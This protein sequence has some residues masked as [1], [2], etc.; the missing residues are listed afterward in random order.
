MS[1]GVMQEIKPTIATKV[2]RGGRNCSPFM[3][4]LVIRV[5]GGRPLKS[6]GP[7]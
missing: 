3:R 7:E 1:K 4:N 6:R 2:T 5:Q